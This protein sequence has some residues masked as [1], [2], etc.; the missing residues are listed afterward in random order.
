MILITTPEEADARFVTVVYDVTDLPAYRLPNGK[1]SPPYNA[2]MKLISAT[3]APTTWGDVGGPGSMGSFHR[4]GI[5]ALVI[6]QTPAVHQEIVDILAMLRKLRG[7]SPTKEELDSLPPPPPPKKKPEEQN[8]GAAGMG[9]MGG[10]L[11]F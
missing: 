11:F 6:S 3:V 5:Q 10:G 4:G 9:G 1:V 2:L 7:H 8:S